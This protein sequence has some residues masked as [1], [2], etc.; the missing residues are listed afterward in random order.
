[1]Y[2]SV[3]VYIPISKC[4]DKVSKCIDLIDHRVHWEH[5]VVGNAHRV[6]QRSVPLRDV[7]AAVQFELGECVG[8]QQQKHQLNTQLAVDDLCERRGQTSV[9]EELKRARAHGVS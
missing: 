4:M 3:V 2:G 1:M 8:T 6:Q 9:R 7:V 5:A